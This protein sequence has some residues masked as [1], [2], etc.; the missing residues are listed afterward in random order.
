MHVHTYTRQVSV[1]LLTTP[2]DGVERASGK[3]LPT[4]HRWIPVLESDF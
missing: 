4:F 1:L 2:T 3:Y